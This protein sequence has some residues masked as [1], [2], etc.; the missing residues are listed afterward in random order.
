M[1]GRRAFTL[2]EMLLATVL[3]TLLLIGLLAV[4]AD[5]G[6][7]GMAAGGQFGTLF[8]ADG[9]PDSA[10]MAEA[11]EAWLPLLREDLNHTARADVSKAN[12]LTLVGQFALDA[13]GRARTHRPARVR[14][15]LTEI[16]G[17]RWLIRRQEALD[18][19]TNEDVQCD[20]VCSGV[21]RFEVVQSGDEP[22]I[23]PN[24]DRSGQANGGSVWRLRVWTGNS[25]DPA[26]DRVV[27]VQRDGGL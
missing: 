5:L 18:S 7:S 27:N 12:E 20:L 2:L 8:A 1:V 10:A 19:W 17:R 13:G 14:Y 6:A 4:V 21:T 11:V 24:A 23:Q 15:R 9:S 3:S 22:R 25:R 16:N 26:M